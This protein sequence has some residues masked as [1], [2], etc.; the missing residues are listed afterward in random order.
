MLE[1][2]ERQI[3]LEEPLTSF[4]DFIGI[5]ARGREGPPIDKSEPASEAF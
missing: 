5:M 2:I 4:N 1:L 3:E